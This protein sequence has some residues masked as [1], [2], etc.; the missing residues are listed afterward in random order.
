MTRV[1]NNVG[2]GVGLWDWVSFRVTFKIW[3]I[4][5]IWSKIRVRIKDS[6]WGRISFNF[7]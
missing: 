7:S 5:R 1:P 3:T 4:I 6:V 2:I